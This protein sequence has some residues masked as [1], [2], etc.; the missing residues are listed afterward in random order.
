MTMFLMTKPFTRIEKNMKRNIIYS[1]IAFLLCS[2]GAG[3][4]LPVQTEQRDSVRIE[5]R[6]ETKYIKDTVWMKIPSQ[7]AENTTRDT[8]SHLETDYAESDARINP[9]GT[10]HHSLRNK[11]QKQPV[12]VD[13]PQTQKDSIVYRDRFISET[14]EVP[15]D[16]TSW[17]KWQMRS[18]WI[19]LSGLAVFVIRKPLLALI[20]RFI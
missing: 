14:I 2:C 13:V 9:D 19:L 16:L 7:S 11:P 17:Q 15:R 6:K 4:H 20:R 5:V 10:L 12:P 1:I 18:F 3:K 8:S